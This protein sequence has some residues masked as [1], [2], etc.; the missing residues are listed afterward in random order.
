MISDH[1][2]NNGTVDS[3]ESSPSLAHALCLNLAQSTTAR[4]QPLLRVLSGEPSR[5]GV[6]LG[7]REHKVVWQGRFYW[8]TSW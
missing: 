4:H 3:L 7:S 5:L 1:T 2:T 6:A 8:S